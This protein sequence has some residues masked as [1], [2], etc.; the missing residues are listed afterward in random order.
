MFDSK[1]MEKFHVVNLISINQN[2][3]SFFIGK[4]EAN[5]IKNIF[6]V[7]PAEY[8]ISNLNIDYSIEDMEIEEQIDRLKKS[9]A[10]DGYQRMEVISRVNEIADYISTKQEYHI[11]P[12]SIIFAL[13][14]ELL[15]KKEDINMYLNE[16]TYSFFLFQDINDSFLFIPKILTESSDY[17]PIFVI[18]G[19]HRMMGIKKYVNKYNVKS[20]EI[21]G[22]FL[23]NRDKV[24]QAEIFKTVNYKIKK[25]NKSY[26]YQIMGEFEEGQ[27]EYIYLHYL[28][29]LLNEVEKS[30]LYCRIKMLGKSYD[31]INKQTI[32]QA[33]FVEHMYEWLFMEKTK[34]NIPQDNRVRRIPV[35]RYFYMSD[36]EKVSTRLIVRYFVAIRKMFNEHYSSKGIEWDSEGN[37]LLKSI[38][39]G[40]FIEIFPIIYIS[41]MYEKHWLENQEHFENIKSNDFISYLKVIFEQMDLLQVI[42]R[43]YSQGSGKGFIMKFA[44]LLS[45]KVISSIPNY[46]EAEEKYVAWFREQM[47]K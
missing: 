7:S 37:I 10:S 39:I 31:S 22:T 29:R 1:V 24:D 40:A 36:N 18:D 17:K 27:N 2:D 28:A 25:V 9:K 16:K 8:S 21:V 11:I 43:E 35:L 23:I 30:P 26:Y 44:G 3:E 42:E 12:N 14:A 34:L 46:D 20:F 4:V 45:D 15:L 41:I 19:N 6:T 33:F 5:W 47:I 32:S 38:G 13:S